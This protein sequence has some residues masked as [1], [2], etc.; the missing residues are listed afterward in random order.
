MPTAVL[1]ILLISDPK[2]A[3]AQADSSAAS[4]RHAVRAD[5]LDAATYDGWKQFR[6]VCDRCHGEDA[7]GTSFAPD[8]LPAFKSTGV[9]S[10]LEA[11]K[12]FIVAGRPAKGMP[13]A[14]TLGLA[15]E[16]FAGLYQYLQGRSAGKYAG[17]RP[18]LRSR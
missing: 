1:L 8:L 18:V 14:V 9:A 6:L 3:W 4:G 10:S 12:T 11:F 17:G 13:P 5:T 15:P 16:H 7:R 2:G